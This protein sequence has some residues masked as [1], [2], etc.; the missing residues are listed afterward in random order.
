MFYGLGVPYSQVYHNKRCQI[1]NPESPYHYSWE[2]KFTDN[3][4]R[5]ILDFTQAVKAVKS[6]SRTRRVFVFYN[7][8]IY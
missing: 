1:I 3:P 7:V 6:T 8:Y 4:K 2:N 5:K